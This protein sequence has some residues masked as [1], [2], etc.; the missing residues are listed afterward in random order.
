MH[1]TLILDSGAFSTWSRGLE[2][3]IEDYIAFIFA[4]ADHVDYY[5]NLD[6]IPGKFGRV[7]TAA[8]V[9]ASAQASWD[10]MLFMEACGLHP[11]PVFH[12]G[13]NFRW[14]R[15]IK[16]HNEKYICISPANDRPTAQKR[17]W[18]DRVFSE[19]ADSDGTPCVKTHALGVTSVPLLIRYPWHSADSSA[20]TTATARG[21]IFVPR[22][23][24]D[25]SHDYG[26]SPFVVYMSGVKALQPDE[27]D[28]RSLNAALKAHVESYIA[29]AGTTIKE[30]KDSCVERA[31]IC[32][33][34]F[35]MFEKQGPRCTAFKPH[36][37]SF[38]GSN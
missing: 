31:R 36:K 5:V 33:Y 26:Q 30:A 8:E 19:L 11:M 35:K 7:P 12:M 37:T 15:K 4:N 14:L 17:V 21:V 2:I 9:E 1:K 27:R 20:W 28:Y 38:F 16:A 3:C 34:F 13:E 23:K 24:P 10:N 6:V 32:A 29:A 18:L 22:L 25:G